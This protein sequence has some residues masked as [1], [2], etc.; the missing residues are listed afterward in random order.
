MWPAF[1]IVPAVSPDGNGCFRSRRNKKG[2]ESCPNWPPTATT[3]YSST[4]STT[5]CSK[6]YRN[7]LGRPSASSAQPSPRV[8]SPWPGTSRS[9]RSTRSSSPS[10][11]LSSPA[12]TSPS[13][14]LLHQPPHPTDQHTTGFIKLSRATR[15][16][17]PSGPA[18]ERPSLGFGGL[19]SWEDS[20]DRRRLGI[21]LRLE[22]R[23]TT[24]E[25]VQKRLNRRVRDSRSVFSPFR[26][27]LSGWC[28][29][30]AKNKQKADDT[31]IL[32]LRRRSK[33]PSSQ[34]SAQ[35][36]SS[37]SSSSSSAPPSPSQSK[38][39]SAQSCCRPTSA[40][41]SSLDR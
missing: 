27:S 6:T 25:R 39:K 3:D 4:P 29:Q 1:L 34:P 24:E 11:S 22:R 31:L 20:F 19:S 26:S 30:S 32:D 10:R 35:Y 21:E 36:L 15:S 40:C 16:A 13:N 37:P 7:P 38:P 8:T 33:P 14:S 28:Y 41:S 2:S 9:S 17:S 23:P 18:R 5:G 12:R